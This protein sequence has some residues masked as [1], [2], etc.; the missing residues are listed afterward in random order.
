MSDDKKPYARKGTALV[1]IPIV[2][3]LI[4]LVYSL[5][6]SVATSDEVFLE[7]PEGYDSCVRDTEYMRFHHWELLLELREKVV[8]HGERQE[9]TLDKCRSCHQNR[10]RFC[11]QCHDAVSLKP[12]CWGCHYYPEK[13][14]AESSH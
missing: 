1:A 8:R 14:E 2:I 11:N 10:E 4:P 6:G 9:I 13:P 3:L 12:D 7:L 5:V